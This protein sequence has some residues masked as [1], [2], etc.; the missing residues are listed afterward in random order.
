MKNLIKK[1]SLILPLIVLTS[2]H[3][4]EIFAAEGTAIP[5]TTLKKVLNLT[6]VDETTGCILLSSAGELISPLSPNEKGRACI[7]C[8]D[9][10][11][12]DEKNNGKAL[13]AACGKSGAPTDKQKEILTNAL[14]NCDQLA[15]LYKHFD[16]LSKDQRIQAQSNCFGKWEQHPKARK[17]IMKPDDVD[18][19]KEVKGDLPNWQEVSQMQILAKANPK[20]QLTQEITEEQLKAVIK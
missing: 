3:I 1:I 6:R 17:A 13:A 9:N 8:G 18:E 4:T 19:S 12:K 7:T 16:L 2:A 15:L 20:G 14:T 10:W 11:A 5:A